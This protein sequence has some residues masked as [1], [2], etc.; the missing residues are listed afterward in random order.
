MVF[1]VRFPKP[2]SRFLREYNASLLRHFS[3][4][5]VFIAQSDEDDFFISVI[6]IESSQDL[7]KAA[8]YKEEGASTVAILHT[9]DEIDFIDWVYEKRAVDRFIV[10]HRFFQEIVSRELYDS[11]RA[12]FYPFP[13]ENPGFT[14][15][16]GESIVIPSDA[17]DTEVV[18]ALRER[19]R[20]IEVGEV[21]GLPSQSE[22]AAI[23]LPYVEE[24][25]RTI[26]SLYRLLPL[27]RPVIMSRIPVFEEFA[28]RELTPEVLYTTGRPDRAIATVEKILSRERLREYFTYVLRG[29]VMSYT[30]HRFSRLLR[31]V[32][33]DITPEEYRSLYVI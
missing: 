19:F 24:D 15:E 30:F 6:H 18:N 26:Y 29:Y 25:F 17:T 20:V 22:V 7:E 2:K 3:R 32:F 28:F 27:Q 10:H 31:R 9:I 23:V 16:A 8:K 4:L 33:I 12:I 14:E 11:T 1:K 21:D 13:V 5:N